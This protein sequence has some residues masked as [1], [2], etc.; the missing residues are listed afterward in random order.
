MRLRNSG[1]IRVNGER[2]LFQLRTRLE[3][4]PAT[5][6]AVLEAARRLQR[7]VDALLIKDV[8]R[9]EEGIH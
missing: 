5:V 2:E 4:Y 9:V 6:E 8:C 1:G 3:K 7:P